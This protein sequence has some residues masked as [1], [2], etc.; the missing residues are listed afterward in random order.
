MIGEAVTF[1]VPWISL[2]SRS[3][4]RANQGIPRYYTRKISKIR[5][6]IRKFNLLENLEEFNS[7]KINKF[8]STVKLTF[9]TLSFLQLIY[10]YSIHV[11][12]NFI[13]IIY[14]GCV[15]KKGKIF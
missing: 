13:L 10:N 2:S 9:F 1:L 6:L 14:T 3:C 11:Y 8:F 12:Q 4:N 15:E 7:Q 5:N